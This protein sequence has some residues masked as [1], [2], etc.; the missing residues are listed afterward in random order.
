MIQT[1]NALGFLTEIKKLNFS[2]RDFL[3]ILGNSK[4]S[5]EAY[6]EI[7][8]NQELTFSRL[9]ELLDASPLTADDYARLLSDAHARVTGSKDDTPAVP[10]YEEDEDE[11]DD[12]VPA[13]V[14]NN[15][16]KLILCFFMAV[17]LIGASFTMRWF[18]TG[19]LW[20]E[21]EQAIVYTVPET[22]HEL[23]ER[24]Q[25]A[26]ALSS[27]RE[28][29]ET[30]S[31][32]LLFNDRYI[33][34]VI[35]NTLYVVEFRNGNMQKA[36]EIRYDGEVIRELYLLKEQLYVIS[37][38]EYEGSYYHE[39]EFETENEPVVLFVTN[40]FLQKSIS[41]R[42]YDAWEFNSH[43]EIVF[44][45]DG[46]YNSV[47]LHQNKL[48]LTTDYTPH[49]PKA[50]SDL[51]AFVPSYTIGGEK[52]F[53]AIANIYAPP[54]MLMNTEMTVVSVIEK[55][56]GSVFA[57]VG[58]AGS[59]YSGED[60]LFITQ[61]FNEKSRIIRLNVL[62]E[63]APVF[64][65][66]DG[67]I[68]DINEKYGILR[69]TAYKGEKPSLNIFNS[70]LEPLSGDFAQEEEPP[71]PESER[72]EIVVETDEDGRRAGI[73][74]NMQKGE[75]ITATYLII[76]ENDIAGNWNPFLFADAEN[77]KEAVFISEKAG[78]ILLPV[79]FSNGIAT[80]EKLLIFDYDRELTLRHEIVYIYE[81]GGGN[82]R[83]RAVL[84]DGYIYSFWDTTVVSAG[85]N[86]GAVIM[87]IEL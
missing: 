79:Y 36:G 4:I 49:E 16:G 30:D 39:Y 33:F 6:S 28:K 19:S 20:L 1:L 2:G 63:D 70:A 40:D 17:M 11:E 56:G 23:S 72:L 51:A 8:E 47:L 29:A 34:N 37:E 77:D 87:K 12:E 35:E 41:V 59:V 26:L 86:D 46:G 84:A 71:L 65:D 32:T 14:A 69:V 68:A 61:I 38:G 44:T 62:G 43:P 31:K 45:V 22:Y 76:A 3:E 10:Q 7:K 74:L 27:A 55:S 73:R 50:Y 64:H 52:Q 81:L 9:V 54:A 48:V 57:A 18:Q 85:A 25:G 53:V 83:R 66:I 78:I 67:S 42:V 15:K 5:N 24:L 60:A 82:E 80:V 13:S 21:R 75:E 58:G